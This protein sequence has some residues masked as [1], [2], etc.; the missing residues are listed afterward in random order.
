MSYLS[1]CYF[2]HSKLLETPHN[3]FS[4]V[5]NV[6]GHIKPKIEKRDNKFFTYEWDFLD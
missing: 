6:I 2:T 4:K 3:K 5:V 1:S